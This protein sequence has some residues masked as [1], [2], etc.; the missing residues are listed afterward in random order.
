MFRHALIYIFVCSLVFSILP[1]VAKASTTEATVTADVLRI[2]SGPGTTYD[3]ISSLKQ[4]DKVTILKKEGSWYQIKKGSTSGYVAAEF[5]KI[6]SATNS[7]GASQI[8]AY[9]N[10]SVSNLNIRSTP[11]TSGNVIGKLQKGDKVSIYKLDTNWLEISY[12]NQTAYVSREFVVIQPNSSTSPTGSSSSSR[13]ETGTITATTLNVRKTSS[14]NGEIIGKVSKGETYAIL[15][16]EN[17]WVQIKLTSGKTGWIASWFMARNETTEP[18]NNKETSTKVTVLYDGTNIRASATTS[19]NVISRVNSGETLEASSLKDNW[20]EVTL[21]DG[22]K[23]FIAGWL[24]QADNA[25]QQV[26][27]PG[28]EQY[29]K[30]KVIIIDPG[31]GGKDQGAT[32]LK[33]TYEKHLT[34]STGLLLYE[35]LK[36]AGANVM[37][38]RNN[39]TFL[40]LSSRVGI[41]HTYAADAFISIHFDSIADSSVKGMTAYYYHNYQKSLAT[42]VH[43]ELVSQ[44]KLKDRGVRYGD[45]HVL[46]ENKRSS[47]LVELGYLSNSSEEMLVSSQSYQ[48][49][50][51]TGMYQGIA[52][53]FKKQ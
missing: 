34:L 49:K 23:G 9:G 15:A 36:A 35:K 37:M 33:G 47:V 48:V 44:T 22:K 8:Q 39:D 16:E 26:T 17:N 5:L 10:V 25:S 50:A 51:A 31:H 28:M 1:P 32:G 30:D 53:Y 20:Y 45:Y 46:R 13:A 41:S 27:K 11:S 21:K 18:S 2:R 4:G 6:S 42:A 12:Q 38:T 43:E 3:I 19:S 14:L 40:S 24:V 52:K 29:V 7:G